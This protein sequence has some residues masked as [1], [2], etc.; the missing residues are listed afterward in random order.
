[1][2][3]GLDLHKK[4]SEFAVMDVG[5]NLLKQGRIENNLEEMKGFSESLPAQS[6]IVIESS[7]T[8]YW[9]H[10]LLSQRHQVTLSNPIK[11][12][13]IASAKV[14]TDKIDSIMLATLLRGGFV[15]ECYVPSDE[16]MRFRELV[17]YRANLVRE[18]TRMKNQ[19]HAYLLMN[20]VSVTAYP[21]SKGFVDE[22]RKIEDPRV[23]GYLRLIDGLNVE[24]REASS[25]IREKAKSNEDAI[26]LMSIPGI[27]FFSALLIISEIGEIGRFEDSSSLVGYSGLAPS[28]HSSGGKTYHGPIMKSGSR[29]L[30]WIM[31][32]CARVN[33]RAE[34]DGTIATFYRRLAKKKG[35]QKAI[36]AASAKL[37]K[38]VYWVLKEKRTYHS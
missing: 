31:G 9:A 3:V 21:F 38:I 27:S 2:F 7:S 12:K 24:I 15:A 33:M 11:N 16:T 6:S 32:Q 5:G 29:Y 37:L 23:R 8:W 22:L 4:Y 10:R 13:A 34:P 35:D 1:M 25:T 19:V 17:R 28:T 36:V 20:N 14:K 18:R 26:L 30:R